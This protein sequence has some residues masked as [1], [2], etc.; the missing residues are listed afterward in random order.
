M[1]GRGIGGVDLHDGVAA[2]G[3]GFQVVDFGGVGLGFIGVSF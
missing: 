2:G 1:G 3:L